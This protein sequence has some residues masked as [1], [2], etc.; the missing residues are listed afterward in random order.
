M[1]STMNNVELEKLWAQFKEK[2]N[3]DYTHGLSTHIAESVKNFIETH[4]GT[5]GDVIACLARMLICTTYANADQCTKQ[6]ALD[7]AYAWLGYAT[8]YPLQDGVVVS[9]D[10]SKASRARS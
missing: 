10:P 8:V 7:F 2:E 6:A 5:A 3:I 1:V 4:G 9:A